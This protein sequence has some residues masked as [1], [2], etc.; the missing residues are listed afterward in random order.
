[1]SLNEAIK[2][3]ALRL[4]FIL[5][6]V[7][8]PDIPPHMSTY[9][10]W[11]TL[12]RHGSMEYL[13]ECK[14]ILVLAASYP[15]PATIPHP[16]PTSNGGGVMKEGRISSYALD[17]DYHL[18]LPERLKKLASFIEKQ[19]DGQ[20][21]Q[22]WYTD[23]GPILERELAQ[24]AGLGWI[25]KNACLINPTAG[26]FFFLAELLLGIELETDA[27]FMADRCGTCSR[28]IEACPT[29][30]IQPN[31]TI[32]ARNCISYLTIENKGEIPTNLRSKMG[33]WVF[34]C[35]MCQMVCPWNRFT[36]DGNKQVFAECNSLPN[37]DLQT[38]LLITPQGF[39]RKFKDNPV[40]RAR[41]GGYLRNVAV[42][43]GNSKDVTAI[44]VLEKALQDHES[45][46][47][48]HAAW[49]L[50]QIR[51]HC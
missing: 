1:M 39:N 51:K 12:G 32:D 29:S 28:C 7:T 45:L 30:C 41:R 9:E 42:A 31:R 44:P 5:A 22:R 36:P 21:L 43:L 13:P 11:L 35:D 40:R 38:E 4:G 14:S 23:T 49:A 25:G 33:N 19:T 27:P 47:R 6:G 34:G 48:G 16:I 15:N 46:I 8:S 3:E 2:N 20:I 18:S 50:E 10:N 17:R 26:S 24:R 37:P